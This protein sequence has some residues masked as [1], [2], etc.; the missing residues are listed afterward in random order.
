[1]AAAVAGLDDFAV[2]ADGAVE[3]DIDADDL[4]RL[5]RG[6]RVVGHG[7]VH[8][9]RV[10]LDGDRDDEHDQEHQHHVDQRRGV[11]VHHHFAFFALVAYVHCHLVLLPTSGG[12]RHRPVA[13]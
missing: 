9:D 12:C 11:D 2:P 10:R 6:L 3:V 8:L 5:G 13:R 7:H 4:R 1:M